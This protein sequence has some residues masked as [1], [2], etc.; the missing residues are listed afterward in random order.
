[1]MD[2]AGTSKT[3]SVLVYIYIYIYSSDQLVN[4]GIHI[5]RFSD[6]YEHVWG[7]NNMSKFR[8]MGLNH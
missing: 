8:F 2:Q 7:K 3:V 5:H 6:R 1:M 4:T